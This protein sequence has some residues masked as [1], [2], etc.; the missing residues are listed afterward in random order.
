MSHLQYQC[1]TYLPVV[2]W[3]VVTTKIIMQL[4]ILNKLRFISYPTFPLPFTWVFDAMVTLSH[5]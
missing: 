4:V 2:K 1:P 5:L 3:A